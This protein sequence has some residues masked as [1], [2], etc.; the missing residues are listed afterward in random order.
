[1]EFNWDDIE[2]Y[3]RGNLSEEKRADFE[4]ALQ[5][6]ADLRKEVEDYRGLLRGFDML[7]DE[8]KVRSMMEHWEKDT[9]SSLSTTPV[10]KLNP[11]RI[12]AIAAGLVLLLGAF[13]FLGIQPYSDNALYAH[14]YTDKN[15]ST[16]IKSDTSGDHPLQQ[17]FD[18]YENGQ[19]QAALNHFNS[20]PVLDPN[21]NTSLYYMSHS[22]M[23]L[24][25]WDNAI[26]QINTI[27]GVRDVRYQEEAEWLRVL[28]YLQ[29]KDPEN[30]EVTLSELVK[31]PNH[32][33]NKKAKE[34]Q[35][36]LNSPLRSLVF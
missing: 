25:D 29:K 15:T 16:A 36:E 1:M 32:S 31:N 8:A 11:F 3:I 10:R 34:L 22:Y 19:F 24:K 2:S 9:T 4:K 5:S 26:T 13:Y 6:D 18:A 12:S 30:L 17:G 14:H 7:R 20:I 21:Y 28:C 23:K 33:Y 27:I 35:S